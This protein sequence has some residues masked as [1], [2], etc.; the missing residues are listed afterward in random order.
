LCSTAQLQPI[1]I[2]LSAVVVGLIATA[3]AAALAGISWMLA[4]PFIGGI[5]FAAASTGVITAATATLT[6]ALT[7]IGAAIAVGG[8]NV[9]DKLANICN[10]AVRIG[11]KQFVRDLVGAFITMQRPVSA[12]AIVGQS[13]RLRTGQTEAAG[14]PRTPEP[15]CMREIDGLEFALSIEPGSTALF[16]FMNDVF[17]LTDEFFNTNMPMGYAMSLR[18]TRGTAAFLGPQQ[19][20]RTAHVEFI[21]LRGLNGQADFISRL[22]GIAAIR[23]AIP[24][25]GLMHTLDAAR[26]EALYADNLRS[27]RLALGEIV[28][29]AR[30]E[31]FRTRFSR[32]RNLEPMSGCTMPRPLVDLVRDILSALSRA[33]GLRASY[34]PQPDKG[35]KERPPDSSSSS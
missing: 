16:D 23:G 14:S 26:V 15:V 21:I 10:L 24:H 6:T 3:T 32:E 29:G 27:W 31:T 1:L 5:L 28:Q 13:F 9:A 34:L 35:E 20:S 12:T 4:I 22:H 18:F 19:F 30:A 25:W 33:R 8:G 11:Q 7:A 2:A 17:A